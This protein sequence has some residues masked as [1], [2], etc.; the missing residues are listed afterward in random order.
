MT[1]SSYELPKTPITVSHINCGGMCDVYAIEWPIKV[2]VCTNCAR[3]MKLVG[4][5]AETKSIAFRDI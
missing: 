4:H 5:N 3:P 2:L 1:H